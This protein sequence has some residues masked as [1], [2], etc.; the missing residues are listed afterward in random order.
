ML[1]SN[2]IPDKVLES[3]NAQQFVNVL[4]AL[5]IYKQEIIAEAARVNNPA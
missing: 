2:A 1:L 5:H 4:D 3:S